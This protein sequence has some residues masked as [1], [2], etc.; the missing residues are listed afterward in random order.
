MSEQRLRYRAFL[1]VVLATL[2]V[3]LAPIIVSGLLGKVLPDG[4]I[5]TSDKVTTGLVTLLGTIGGLLFRRV[6]T[7]TER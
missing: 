7:G 6:D 3:A 5:A 1:A 2:V 4:L